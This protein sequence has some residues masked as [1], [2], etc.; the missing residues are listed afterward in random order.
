MERSK[1][2]PSSTDRFGIIRR[3]PT[4][5]PQ[6]MDT[7]EGLAEAKAYVLQLAAED[8][9]EFYIYA[10]ENGV[11]IE[12]FM[13]VGI[14]QNSQSIG[15]SPARQLR[16]VP[17]SSIKYNKFRDPSAARQVPRARALIELTDDLKDHYSQLASYL[18]LN[19]MLPPS[20]F[21]VRA[22]GGYS[23]MVLAR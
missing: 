13:C 23:L 4:G 14:D 15:E 19:G 11:I 17:L 20:N 21:A 10:E 2:R 9:G 1:Q 12:D 5:V 6:W 8:P 18:R 3:L 22:L 7:K 16:S